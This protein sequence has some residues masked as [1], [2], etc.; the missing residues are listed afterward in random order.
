[1]SD[2]E[3]TENVARGKATALKVRRARQLIIGK[4]TTLPEDVI[5]RLPLTQQVKL[6]EAIRE[7]LAEEAD[8]DGGPVP[9]TREDGE[10]SEVSPADSDL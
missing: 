6:L 8:E 3:A 1:V 4:L 2:L 9:T 10:G 7:D 5:E